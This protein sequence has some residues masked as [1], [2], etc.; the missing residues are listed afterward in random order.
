MKLS[1]LY[2]PVK[3]LKE[4]LA[5][6][7]DTLGLE[8]HWREGE[9]TCGLTLPGTEVGLMLDQDTTETKAGP[10]FTVPDVRA[11][12]EE[13]KGALLFQGEPSRIPPGW[14]AAFEDPAGNVIRVMDRTAD[15]G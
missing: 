10:F 2:T 3:D 14:Y 7:R 15:E 4:A 11:F 13:K 8:E 6:Y 12:Y 1:Y 9:L 5:F